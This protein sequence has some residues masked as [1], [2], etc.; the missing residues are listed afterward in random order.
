MDLEAKYYSIEAYDKTYAQA[1]SETPKEKRSLKH[2]CRRERT[3][4]RDK[5][6]HFTFDLYI[7]LEPM[8]ETRQACSMRSKARIHTSDTD[9]SVKSANTYMYTY[10]SRYNSL[11]S[12]ES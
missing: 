8:T 6:S 7:I 2:W 9:Y 10:T 11:M 12:A 1:P 4:K 3:Q 5:Q